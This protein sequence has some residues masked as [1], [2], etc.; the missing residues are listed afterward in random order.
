MKLIY[1]AQTIISEDIVAY[2][3]KDELD[4]SSQLLRAQQRFEETK[5]VAR[6]K[7]DDSG[8]FKFYE[9]NPA[10]TPAN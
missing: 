5:F 10:W 3:V 9:L 4:L 2:V 1:V 7:K 8:A 6:P